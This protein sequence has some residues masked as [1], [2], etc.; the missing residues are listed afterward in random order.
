MDNKIISFS[1]WGCEPKYTIGAVK[2]AELA[3]AIYPT[4]I[5]RF[6]CGKSVSDLIISLLESFDNTEIVKMDEDGDWSPLVWR[7][8]ATEDSDVMIS[9]DADSRLSLRE[10]VAV[11][12]WL[13]SD[14][15]FH[16]MRD[17]FDHTAKILGGMWGSRNILKDMRKMIEDYQGKPA[18]WQ[19]DQDFLREKVYPLIKDNVMVHDEFFD[20][21]PFPTARVGDEFVGQRCKII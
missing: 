2:N 1:L 10:K 16:I 20:N 5:C 7:F 4:W 21:C 14:K 6:Y 12:E 19:Y 11:D 9:R 13:A 17:A 15:D 3:L 18:T 8:Y